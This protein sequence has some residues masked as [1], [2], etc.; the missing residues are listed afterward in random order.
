V[1]H[2]FYIQYKCIY[3]KEFSLEVN[4]NSSTIQNSPVDKERL[5]SKNTTDNEKITEKR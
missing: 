4:L 5:V 1:E 3:E 2:W